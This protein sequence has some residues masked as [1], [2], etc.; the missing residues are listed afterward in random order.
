MT[1]DL[2]DIGANLT[3][4][5]F[6]DDRAAVI[7]RARAA[8]VR[9]MIVTGSTV[10]ESRAAVELAVQY[11]GELYATAGVHPH[12]ARELNSQTIPELR[13]IARDPVVVAVGECGLDYFRNFSP[14]EDQERAFHAQLDL[15]RELQA[16][17]FLHQ[18][19]AHSRFVAILREHR[20]RLACVVAHCFTGTAEELD[21]YL[22]LD[23]HIGIT[24]WIC[25]ERR[26]AHLRELVRRIPL[27]RLMVETDSPYLLPRDLDPKP[28]TRRNEPMYLAHVLRVVAACRGE[29]PQ[30]LAAATS[31]TA[32]R[33]FRIEPAQSR[34]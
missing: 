4:E 20:S 8:G 13:E 31:A 12:R 23:L 11:R 17:A 5:S 29:D 24:G 3:H 27:E 1:L 16:P 19:D 32:R 6:R 2:V 9:Q 25:D 34:A 22:A 28:K 21:D 26:G 15:A 30:S 7:E 14:H 33:F 18:R 10:D